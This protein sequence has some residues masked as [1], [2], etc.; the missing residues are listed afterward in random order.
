MAEKIVPN[1]YELQGQGVRVGYSTSSIAG[2]AQL[3]FKKGRKTL[4]FTGDEINVLDTKSGALITVTIATTPDRSFT[5]LSFLLPAIQ[6]SKESAKQSF[7]TIGITT[8][9]KTTIA[10][11]VS[12]VQQ[13]Y[14]SIQLSGTARHVQFLAQNTA[15]AATGH[16]VK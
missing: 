5:L 4:D 11:P 12:G 7:R 9:Q 13:V 15:S 2:N 14:K 6:L 8:I 1:Q 10:G 16:A 3:S